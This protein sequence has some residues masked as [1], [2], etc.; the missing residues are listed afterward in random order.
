M[1]N[2]WSVR[3]QERV[4]KRLVDLRIRRLLGLCLGEGSFSFDANSL[5]KRQCWHHLPQ[6]EVA[7]AGSRI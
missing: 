6:V 5:R 7:R 4:L 1:I 2:H 3:S